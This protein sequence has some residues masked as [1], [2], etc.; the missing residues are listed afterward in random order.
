M[1]VPGSMAPVSAT[2]ASRR[3]RQFLM[4]QTRSGPYSGSI[5]LDWA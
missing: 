1:M 4:Q 5:K 2:I 3:L